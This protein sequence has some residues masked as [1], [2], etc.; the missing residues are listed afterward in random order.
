LATILAFTL[1]VSGE[2]SIEAL[3]Q[4]VLH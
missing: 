1:T 3:A 2:M 4:L